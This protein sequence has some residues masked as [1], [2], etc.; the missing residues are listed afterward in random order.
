[1]C[2]YRFSKSEITTYIVTTNDVIRLSIWGYSNIHAYVEI[3]SEDYIDF[4][5]ICL[6]CLHKC[7]FI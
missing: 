3:S 1:M 5:E 4:I 6:Q 2:N 7:K